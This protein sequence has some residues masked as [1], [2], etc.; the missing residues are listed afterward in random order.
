MSSNGR[1]A[2]EL[3][4]SRQLSY[5]SETARDGPVFPLHHWQVID[6]PSTCVSSDDFYWPWKARRDG[7]NFPADLR[8]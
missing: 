8:V 2:V 6:T 7:S 3:Q 1:N 5:I 4:T